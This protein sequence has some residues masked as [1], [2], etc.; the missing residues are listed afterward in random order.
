MIEENMAFS[1][2]VTSEFKRGRQFF[3]KLTPAYRAEQ[4]D[5]S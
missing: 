4:I 5:E 2:S 1:I 3:A